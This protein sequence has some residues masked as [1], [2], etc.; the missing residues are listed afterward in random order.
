MI[1]KTGTPKQGLI[2]L[3]HLRC[4]PDISGIKLK[5]RFCFALG[6]SKISSKMINALVVIKCKYKMKQGLVTCLEYT[7]RPHKLFEEVR[8]FK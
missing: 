6:C 8:Q 4:S 2:I 7:G 5:F 1:S 3:I